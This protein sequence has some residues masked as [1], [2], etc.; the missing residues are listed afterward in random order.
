MK[1]ILEEPRPGIVVACAW[2]MSRY[3]ICVGSRP[4]FFSPPTTSSSTE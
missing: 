4:I 2:L 1:P 3:L